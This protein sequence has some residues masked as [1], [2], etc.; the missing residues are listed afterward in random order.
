MFGSQKVSFIDVV[1]SDFAWINVDTVYNSACY[2][3]LNSAC[4]FFFLFHLR[5]GPLGVIGS[6]GGGLLWLGGA[7][8]K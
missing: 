6:G 3:F 1:L 2:F 4:Y 5:A 8:K 7:T